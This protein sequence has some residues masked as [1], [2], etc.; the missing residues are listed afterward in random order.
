M[1]F[2][3]G[4]LRSIPIMDHQPWPRTGKRLRTAPTLG[5]S[6]ISQAGTYERVPQTVPQ[7]VLVNRLPLPPPAH[8]PQPPPQAHLALCERPSSCG[9]Q[10]NQAFYSIPVTG[11][12]GAEEWGNNWLPWPLE[13][14]QHALHFLKVGWG[15]VHPRCLLTQ[16]QLGG[17][18]PPGSREL[19]GL[20]L[21]VI[22]GLLWP[23]PFPE[24]NSLYARENSIA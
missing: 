17:V 4:L 9:C 7:T 24:D 19:P 21:R 6:C 2:M 12:V 22:G 20:Q 8:C 5:V 11:L 10:G 15:G 18:E 23:W 14:P 3:R 13:A 1:K 16:A